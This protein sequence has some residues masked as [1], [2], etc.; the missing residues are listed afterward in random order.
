MARPT[1]QAAGG[2]VFDSTAEEEYLESGNK[3]R[4][5]MGAIDQAEIAAAEAKRGSLG[6]G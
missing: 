1:S 3:A 6:Y 5:M 2:V 4:A